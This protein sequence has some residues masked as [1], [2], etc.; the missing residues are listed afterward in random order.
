MKSHSCAKLRRVRRLTVEDVENSTKALELQL[1][2]VI[3]LHGFS[4][5]SVNVSLNSPLS[6]NTNDVWHSP[7]GEFA[8]G[9]RPLN[10]DTDPNSK[11]F[12]VAIWYDMIPDKTVVWSARNGYEL[13]TGAML[14]D[15]NFVLLNGASDYVW[16]SFDNPTDTLLLN[17]SLNGNLTCRF[18]DTN[19]TTGRFQLHFKDGNV[20]LSSQLPY[21]SY[22]VI[23]ASG[24]ASRLVATLD[25]NGVFTQYAH[26]RN[27]NAQP[28]WR[29]V[30]YVPDNICNDIFNDYGSGSCGYNS[31]CS[32]EN[33]RPTCNCPYGYSLVDPSNEFGGCQPNF[34]L[35]CGADVHSPP[36]E[37]YEMH[38]STNFNFP[39]GDYET[40]QHYSRQQCQQSCLHDCKCAMAVLGGDVCWMKRFPLRNGRVVEYS[41]QHVVYIKTRLSPDFSPGAADSKKEDRAKP[42]LLGSLIGSLVITGILLVVVTWFILL[43]MNTGT[44][45][46]VAPEWFKN[47]AV[48]NKVDVYS[49]GVMWLEII[50]C[51]RSVLTIEYGEE[52]KAVLTDWACDCYMEGRIDALVEN[53]EEALSDIDRLQNWL[54]IG[55]WCINEQPEMRPTMPIVM[56]VLQGFVQNKAIP[57]PQEKD[58]LIAMNA[59]LEDVYKKVFADSYQHDACVTDRWMGNCMNDETSLTESQGSSLF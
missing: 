36:Q 33:Q 25:F 29:I 2:R 6:T 10:N 24:N 15:G 51:R 57:C 37:L 16:Q 32:M 48:T 28:G 30:R 27:T 35:A 53:D 50:S 1:L 45:G 47:V 31:Y 34:T 21:K 38:E 11:V 8:F 41:D 19:Y 58:V 55:I 14:D 20:L 46:Y 52:E 39:L 22:H 17:Q 5:A 42:I 4:L 40:I 9:F 59:A 12:M 43:K 49:F 18:T 44:R 56:Q 3:Y 54:N 23:D 7:S 13:I 26:P